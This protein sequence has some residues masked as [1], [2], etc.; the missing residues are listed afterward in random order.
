MAKMKSHSDWQV[1]ERYE[2]RHIIGTGSYGAVAEAF[3]RERQEV[4]AIKRMNR[5]F[6]DL[7]DCKRILR[8]VAILNRLDNSNIV[9]LLDIL[10]VYIVLEIADSDLKKLFRTHVFLSE[11]HIKTLLFNLLTELRYIHSKGILHRDLKPANCLV[12]KDCS[13]K[14]CDFGLA[15]TLGSPA[16]GD[17][18]APPPGWGG[19]EGGAEGPKQKDK[20]KDMKRQLTGHVVTRW[21]R[22]PEL[23]LLAENYTEAIDVWSVGCIF[24]EMMNMM[25]ENKQYHTEREPLF[26]GTSC[27]PLSPNRQ[28]A[29]DYRFHT[30]G[31]KDQLNMIFTLIG[32]PKEGET[33]HLDKADAIK[34]VSLFDKRDGQNLSA[35]CPGTSKEGVELLQRMLAFVPSK[36]MTVEE[37]LAHPYLKDV[38]K[39]AEEKEKK[40]KTDEAVTQLT[41]PFDD[42]ARMDE[43]ALRLGFLREMCK[44]HPEIAKHLPEGALAAERGRTN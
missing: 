23:I 36:R 27:F 39:T 10:E 42:N 12:N 43:P 21:Y 44:F 1:P 5:V 9:Q 38:K 2:V 28:H 7:V 26:P 8:E 40:K 22:A 31:N 37:A 15:R 16:P 41:L 14:I 32:T 6:E 34:Y 11:L 19:G 24:A 4:V 18:P 20:Q 35:R 13:V 25:K 17:L 29:N 3:D 33:D 30:K